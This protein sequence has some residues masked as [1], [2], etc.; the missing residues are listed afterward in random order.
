MIS[1]SEKTAAEMAVVLTLIGRPT[2]RVP[3][4]GLDG[5]LK[6][7]ALG[8]VNPFSFQEVTDV[9]QSGTT[10]PCPQIEAG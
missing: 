5:D 7:E 2:A 3:W 8:N 4:A 6:S 9:F 1:P 10:L